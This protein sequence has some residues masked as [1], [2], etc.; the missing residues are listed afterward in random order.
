MSPENLS[1]SDY[2]A[3]TA[4][5]TAS[6]LGQA[7]QAVTQIAENFTAGRVYAQPCQQQGGTVIPA[8]EIRG[9]GGVGAQ[10]E[11]SGGGV[12]IRARPVGA[13][14]IKDGTVVWKPA[15]DLSRVVFR[16]QIVALALLATFAWAFGR[17]TS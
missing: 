8:A 3:G 4:R 12:G 2:A 1:T 15:F 13:Y 16:G 10:G 5:N 14:V 11:Q 7:R 17:S 6:S 9:G